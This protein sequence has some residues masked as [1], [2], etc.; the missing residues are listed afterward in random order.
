MASAV[1]GADTVMAPA[2]AGAGSGEGGANKGG[3]DAPVSPGP[4]AGGVRGSLGRGGADQ[5]QRQRH[6]GQG[7]TPGSHQRV[8]SNEGAVAD[9]AH[10][11]HRPTP[12]Q[13]KLEP[14]QN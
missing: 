8:P 11:G 7:E 3:L 13:P 5:T 4:A 2:A 6:H 14:I 1:A 9:T 12:V 10:T